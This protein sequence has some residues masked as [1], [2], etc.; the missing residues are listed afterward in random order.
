FAMNSIPVH[1]A[2]TSQER[3]DKA[4]ATI[5]KNLGRMVEKEKI[6][7]AQKA[8]TL[9]RITVFTNISEAVGKVDLVIE[10]VPEIFELKQKVFTEVDEAAPDHAI[11]ATNTS[12]ISITKIAAVTW[13]PE[14]C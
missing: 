4:L 9:E 2:E 11:L 10:A 7:E 13:R 3:G 8:E 12:S 5:N 6:K 1:L 14:K